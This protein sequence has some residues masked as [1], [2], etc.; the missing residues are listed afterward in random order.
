MNAQWTRRTVAIRRRALG[1]ATGAGHWITER[2]RRQREWMAP[3]T[4]V[5][6]PAA[7]FA[8]ACA[9]LCLVFGI[10]LDWTELLVAAF[11]LVAL[12]G[13]CVPFILG[14][15]HLTAT[16]DLTLNR[17]VVGE[18]ATGRL[19]VRSTA[20][21][22]TFPLTVELPVGRTVANFGMPS[23]KPGAEHEELFAIPTNRRAVLDLGPVQALR[24]D[25]LGLLRRDQELTPRRELF[26][27]PRTVR[28]H[29]SAAGFI[30]DLEGLTVRKV[31]DNDVAFH[32]LRDYV[33]GD[34]HRFIHWKS[35]ART[36]DLMVRQFEETRRSHLLVV[37]STRLEDY[38]RDDEF[39][40]AVSVAASLAAQAL[41]DEHEVSTLTSTRALN[42]AHAMLLL[43]QFS[44]VDYD[45]L[46]PRL[47]ST[48]RR[49]GS[50]AAGASVAVF[51]CGSV[52]DAAE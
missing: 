42:A 46:A 27:H 16:L 26:V 9:L 34:D 20:G 29:G 5:V 3:V 37:L 13:L 6:S 21:H 31:S 43:D 15:H 40:L 44:G 39:E 11:V 14:Q 48:L 24:S 28:I 41:Y 2:T 33:P 10:R 51:V 36:G 35:S 49:L 32:A 45:P 25:P 30:R 52:A 50:S 38:A 47:A 18:R 17:V 23:L 8:A 12:L 4:D 22:R 1:L 7:W 19:L